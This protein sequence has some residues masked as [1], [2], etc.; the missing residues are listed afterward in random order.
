MK[1]SSRLLSIIDPII[2]TWGSL[3]I[4][5]RG[6]SIKWE[7]G[8]QFAAESPLEGWIDSL[9]D[10]KMSYVM[11]RIFEKG[12]YD[13]LQVPAIKAD[14]E[15]GDFDGFYEAVKLFDEDED[16]IIVLGIIERNLPLDYR[17]LC[18]LSGLDIV[19]AKESV[20]R[21]S[22][23]NL[24]EGK[25]SSMKDRM[26]PFEKGDYVKI[27]D[28]S[29]EDYTKSVFYSDNVFKIVK[30]LD[31]GSLKLADIEVEVPRN[32]IEAIPIDGIHDRNLYYDPIIAASYVAPG[33]PV[34]VH[35]SQRGV[36]YMDGLE[37]T[38]FENKTLRQLVKE[39]NCQ[40]VHE[41]QHCLRDEINNDDLKLNETIKTSM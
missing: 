26:E 25:Y 34:P 28:S 37:N 11:K 22:S 21:L 41:V 7:Q 1:N 31:D 29:Y 33:Q 32:N 18:E 13:V 40:F 12:R 8:G 9:L 14:Y 24:I 19:R 39:R 23:K 5:T 35:H 3:S 16:G 27:I 20:A 15:M 36:Y 6:V 10:K 4:G 2:R 38:R 30:V 17:T